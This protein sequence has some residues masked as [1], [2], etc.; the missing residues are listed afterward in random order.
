MSET[1]GDPW[2]RTE[3]L[4]THLRA[5]LDWAGLAP[6]TTPGGH[7]DLALLPVPDPVGINAGLAARGIQHK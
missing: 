5:D 2:P 7:S 1:V 4:Q 3:A 6:P